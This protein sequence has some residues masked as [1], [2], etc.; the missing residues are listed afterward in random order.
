M[1]YERDDILRGTKL[2]TLGLRIFSCI[3]SSISLGILRY[4]Y[5]NILSIFFILLFP[6]EIQKNDFSN[7]FFFSLKSFKTYQKGLLCKNSQSVGGNENLKSSHWP[8]SLFTVQRMQINICTKSASE[9][10]DRIH[11]NQKRNRIFLWFCFMHCEL[12]LLS[13]RDVLCI[14]CESMC[15][16]LFCVI[17]ISREE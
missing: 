2:F 17:D 16:F 8:L 5:I 9:R 12:N 15:M 11:L 13:F 1:E 7:L 3:S 6:V 4:F 14:I 10:T